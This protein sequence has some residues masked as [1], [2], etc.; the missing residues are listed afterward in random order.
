VIDRNALLIKFLIEAPY[1]PATDWWRAIEIEHVVARGL[2]QGR[3]LDLGCGD[4]KLTSL[5]ISE[6]GQRELI[7]I[8][9]DPAETS[10]AE[11]LGIYSTVHTGSAA[12]IPEPDN[13]FDFVF[14]NS[15]LEHIPEIDKVL[16][17][18]A[19][20]LRPGAHFIFTVPGPGFHSLLGGPWFGG[21]REDLERID[22]RCAHL[23]YWG[24]QDWE[25]H[26]IPHALAIC[27]VDAYLDRSETRRWEILSN[28]TAGLLQ[29]M[30][31]GRKRP[32]D[33]QRTLGIRRSR[34]WMP[35]ILASSIAW[36]ISK[37]CP[38]R[39]AVDLDETSASCLYIDCVKSNGSTART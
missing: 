29:A 4:G 20:V 19:R 14:S 18:V 31:P 6:L 28:C 26:L 24:Q 25:R 35:A 11:A 36:L 16:F 39:S 23:R 15:V 5:I 21:R 7:G 34:L 33:I 37:G 9:L 27:R 22:Q 8:D 17:E 30:L 38:T 32:I 3:G 1:Q 10:A 13:S 12:S 2:P